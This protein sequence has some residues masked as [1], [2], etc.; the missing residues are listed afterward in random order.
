MDMLDH[1]WLGVLA[2]FQGPALFSVAGIPV[3]V[4]LVMVAAGFLTGVLV[5]ATP[6]LAGPMAMAVA[7]P[8]LLS[9]FGFETQALLPVMGFLIGIMKGAT[10]GG[11]VPA[12]TAALGAEDRW[13]RL[14]AYGAARALADSIDV[15]R[16]VFH[17]FEAISGRAYEPADAFVQHLDHRLGVVAGQ[18]EFLQ[19][20]FHIALLRGT[21]RIGCV[22]HM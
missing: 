9:I 12:I 10:I 7:L 19:H 3:P 14:S 16:R 13:I 1:V 5:G 8:I 11:A 15:M 18:A 20:L 2:V 22:A 17:G 6:G 4:T 21:V